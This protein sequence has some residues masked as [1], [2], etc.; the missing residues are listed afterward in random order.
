MF[1]HNALLRSIGEWGESR[2]KKKDAALPAVPLADILYIHHLP[3]P[4]NELLLSPSFAYPVRAQTEHQRR[5][6]WWKWTQHYGRYMTIAGIKQLTFSSLISFAFIAIKHF[7]FDCILHTK[8]TQRIRTH[9]VRKLIR[10]WK[11]FIRKQTDLRWIATEIAAQRR[12]RTSWTF[13]N[14][15]YEEWREERKSAFVQQQQQQFLLINLIFDIRK[16]VKWTKASIQALVAQFSLA[17]SVRAGR[18]VFLR[19]RALCARI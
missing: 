11:Q 15:E 16:W 12:G 18:K 2:G 14:G 10:F 17:P 3:P 8:H 9:F 6:L 19:A 13:M 1:I 4:R 5:A 7:A